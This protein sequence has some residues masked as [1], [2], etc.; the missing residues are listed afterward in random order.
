MKQALRAKMRE[1][2]QTI[3]AI[4]YTEKSVTIIKKL[5]QN[6][7]Y[8]KAKQVLVYLSTQEEVDTHQLV[9]DMLNSEK[10]V[11]APKVKDGILV[12]CQ[13]NK[14]NDLEKGSFDILEPSS[15]IKE[16]H[17]KVM[18]LILVPGLAFDKAGNRLG[19]GGGFYDGLFKNTQGYKIGLAFKEQILEK[20][21]LEDHD[22]PVDLIIT[23]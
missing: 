22:I 8:L 16:E 15:I 11:Y 17:P 7:N 3:P 2:R 4:S 18:D 21:P 1:I 19:Y 5:E 20:I 14:W 6:T 9:K 10:R 13:I 12:I 23:D